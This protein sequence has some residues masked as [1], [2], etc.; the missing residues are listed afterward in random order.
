MFKTGEQPA[1]GGCG[2]GDREAKEAGPWGAGFPGVPQPAGSS[3][4]AR[5]EHGWPAGLRS[6]R[7]KLQAAGETG[8][9]EGEAGR[10]EPLPRAASS[11]IACGAGEPW[12]GSGRL[13]DTGV[14]VGL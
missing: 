1:S 9:Q 13:K 5:A 11:G 8:S 3:G 14:Q 7:P 6:L 2:P 12:D 10:A 4:G